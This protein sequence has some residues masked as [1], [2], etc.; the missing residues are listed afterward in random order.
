VL[1][2]AASASTSYRVIGRWSTA[3][4][5]RQSVAFGCFDPGVERF[6]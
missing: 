3:R 1:E 6:V 5:M 2:P 4:P